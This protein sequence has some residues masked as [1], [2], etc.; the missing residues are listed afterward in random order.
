MTK[1]IEILKSI[2]N[3]L[4]NIESLLEKLDE[5]FEKVSTSGLLKM[6]G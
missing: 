4:K 6:F 3:R 2:D 5:K 1:E